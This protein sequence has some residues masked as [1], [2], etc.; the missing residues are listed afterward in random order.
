MARFDARVTVDTRRINQIIANLEG[1]THDYVRAVAFAVEGVAKVNTP[2]DT[3]ALENSVYTRVGSE[4]GGPQAHAEARQRN[5]DAVLVELPRPKNETTAHVGPGV[6]YG[7]AQE[8]G[9]R[10]Q[11][12]QPFLIPAVQEVTRQMERGF[13]QQA[14][15]VVTDD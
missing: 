6:D 9:T 10:T 11:A 5:P 15:R 1:N 4:D 7:L 3:H 12:G 8:F 14:R 2:K 13:M